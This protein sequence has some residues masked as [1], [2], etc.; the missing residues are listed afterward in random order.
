MPPLP[1]RASRRALTYTLDNRIRSPGLLRGVS[2]A[3]TDL[4][5]ALQ[6]QNLQA[7]MNSLACDAEVCPQLPTSQQDHLATTAVRL[8]ANL[9]VLRCVAVSFIASLTAPACVL[10]LCWTFATQNVSRDRAVAA[11]S[12]QP[13]NCSDQTNTPTCLAPCSRAA[14]PPSLN[15]TRAQNADTER[16]RGH[17]ATGAL[18]HIPGKRQRETEKKQRSEREREMQILDR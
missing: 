16:A 18:A 10:S 2:I 17:D 1:C 8:E 6:S 13:V 9:M 3:H 14:S 12:Q 4:K 7:E 15:P 5:Q 11:A